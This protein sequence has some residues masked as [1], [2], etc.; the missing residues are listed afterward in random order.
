MMPWK[1]LNRL[2]FNAKQPGNAKDGGLRFSIADTGNSIPRDDKR[3][4]TD[5]G[6]TY[7]SLAASRLE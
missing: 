2:R 4:T 5:A 6:L 3:P 1:W 7:K